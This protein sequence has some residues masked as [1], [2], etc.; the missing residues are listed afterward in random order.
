[1]KKKLL[2]IFRLFSIIVI[3]ISLYLLYNWHKENKENKN[4]N[5]NIIN[6]YVIADTSLPNETSTNESLQIDF[7]NLIKTNKDTIGW[8]RVNNTEINYPIVQATDNDYYLTHNFYNNYNS[9]GWIFA[10]YRNNFETLDKNTIVYGHNRRNNSMFGTLKNLLTND[11]FSNTDNCSFDF[12]T[13]TA[14]Y[15]AK[16]FS[17]FKIKTSEFIA[18]IIFSSDDAFISYVNTLREK[19]IYDFKVPVTSNDNI[20]T[21]YTCDNNTNYRIIVSAKLVKH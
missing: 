5:D 17:V 13:T 14:H 9:A 4:L 8:I 19:S 6:E 3:C 12:Y 16:I 21:L 20:I 10:D 7:D 15:T 11:W 1:M 18:K 2:I